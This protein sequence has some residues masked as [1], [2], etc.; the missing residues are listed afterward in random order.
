MKREVQDSCL[1]RILIELREKK[2]YI[3]YFSY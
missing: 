1:Y 3:I 2:L